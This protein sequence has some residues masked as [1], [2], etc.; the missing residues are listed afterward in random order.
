M[1]RNLNRIGLLF[2][3]GVLATC[4]GCGSS[5]EV[6]EV[7][8]RSAPTNDREAERQP[9]EAAMEVVSQFLDR[10][11]RGGDDGAAGNLLTKKSQ[12]ELERIGRTVQPIGS[13]DAHFDVSRGELVPD[14]PGAA[15]VHS[16]WSEP[17]GDGS[18]SEYQVVWAVEQDPEAWRISG[19]AM[20]FEPGQP[21]EI[22]DFEDGERM[23]RLLT[24]SEQPGG[25]ST[26][27]QPP[28]GAAAAGGTASQA[29]A[30]EPAKTR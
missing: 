6:S 1:N 19:L 24:A 22:I 18:R 13:P 3:C 17:N 21:P 25:Q 26:A 11:R 14:Q 2:A 27:N 23:A 30:G 29:A 4:I 15:L 16:V 20:E 28:S 7:A 5:T 10:V 9:E 12:S 8:E